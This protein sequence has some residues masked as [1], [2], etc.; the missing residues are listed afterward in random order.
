MDT[1]KT[2]V[3]TK[4]SSNI[5]HLR[6]QQSLSQEELA[7]L[8]GLNRGNIASYEKGTAEPKICN[9]INLSN[10]Y[11]V[12]VVDLITMDLRC[13]VTLGNAR[14]NYQYEL[15]EEDK[16]VLQ[17]FMEQAEELKTVMESVQ[18]CHKFKMK[19]MEKVPAELQCVISNFDQLCTVGEMLLKAHSNLLE[20]IKTRMK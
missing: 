17:K 1:S 7:N 19:S 10:Y 2:T 14:S 4:L 8:L 5:K 11:K 9:L 13:P 12:S 3:G 15:K 16:V 6:K 20:F 18:I